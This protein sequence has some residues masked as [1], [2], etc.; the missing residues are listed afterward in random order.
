MI[1][2]V[3]MFRTIDLTSTG[4]R[5]RT[6]DRTPTVDRTSLPAADRS[7]ST[8]F[9]AILDA[10]FLSLEPAVDKTLSHR[11]SESGAIP[12]QQAYAGFDSPAYRRHGRRIPELERSNL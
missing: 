1:R 7:W 6:V 12:C 10:L 5:T 8:A 11:L 2:T 3:P 9:D 4:Y